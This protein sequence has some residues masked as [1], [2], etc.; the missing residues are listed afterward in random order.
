MK[1][2]IEEYKF[3]SP[4]NRLCFSEAE[5]DESEDEA[6][7]AQ[8]L[9]VYLKNNRAGNADARADFAKTIFELALSSDPSA[10]KF[11]RKVSQF[12]KYWGDDGTI[13]E[14]EWKKLNNS[15]S[16]E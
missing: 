3:K 5:E 15:E 12:C 7:K 16:E 1:K 9:I 2:M 14:D 10:R 6:Q 8:E 11:I 4:L 13:T